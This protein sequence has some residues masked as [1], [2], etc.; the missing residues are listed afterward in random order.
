MMAVAAYGRVLYVR[1][2]RPAYRLDARDRV[3]LRR[4]RRRRQAHVAD[5]AGRKGRF[6][7]HRECR[8]YPVAE[9]PGDRHHHAAHSRGSSRDADPADH[10]GTR[11]PRI[12]T[13][14]R[15]PRIN[16]GDAGPADHHG[17]QIPRINHGDAGPAD[18][19][20]TRIPRINHGDADPAEKRS[21]ESASRGKE[22]RGIRVPWDLKEIRDI[23]VPWT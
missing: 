16:H 8:A 15:I 11:I 7:R 20:G 23:R 14:T 6:L 12:I 9:G 5:A 19:H 10:H 22:I 21:A 1:Q 13:G 2:R 3:G 18:H 17:T 4:R